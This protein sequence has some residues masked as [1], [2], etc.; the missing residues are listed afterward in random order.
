MKNEFAAHRT[1]FVSGDKEFFVISF[2][3][4]GASLISA[5]AL[6]DSLENTVKAMLEIDRRCATIVNGDR[7]DRQGII[8]ICRA[9]KC[10]I[11]TDEQLDSLSALREN[12]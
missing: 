11:Q 6:F 3:P 4:S 5:A 9:H 8:D 1:L 7:L 12:R 2:V 10:L